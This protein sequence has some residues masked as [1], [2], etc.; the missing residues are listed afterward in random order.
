MDSFT[1][2]QTPK[3]VKLL[4]APPPWTRDTLRL[5]DMLRESWEWPAD[6]PVMSA[7]QAK[8]YLERAED[9]HMRHGFNVLPAWRG[10]RIPDNCPFGVA[11][12]LQSCFLAASYGDIY[13]SRGTGQS[14]ANWREQ[15]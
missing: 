15:A 4:L 12:D 10:L 8:D 1:P 5:W 14:L 9:A 11:V 13:S 6:I 2:W 3:G 7:E